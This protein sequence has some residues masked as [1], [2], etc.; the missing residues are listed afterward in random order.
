MERIASHRLNLVFQPLHYAALVWGVVLTV[1]VCALAPAGL[2]HT[3]TQGSAFNPA[4]TSVAL[5]AKAP[6]ERLLGK[7]AVEPANPDPEARKQVSHVAAIVPIAPLAHRP[8]P[9]LAQPPSASAFPS[10]PASPHAVPW[11]RGPPVA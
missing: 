2:P 10:R 7:H 8:A 9:N 3:A 11:A 4:T 6:R 5:H 1:L